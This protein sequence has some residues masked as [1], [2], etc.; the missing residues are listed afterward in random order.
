MRGAVHFR[1]SGRPL[2]LMGSMEHRSARQDVRH[3]WRRQGLLRHGLQPDDRLVRC[4]TGAAA[5]GFGRTVLDRAPRRCLI[6]RSGVRHVT[7]GT[8]AP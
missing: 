8:R 3:L 7:S 5:R 6:E 1:A 2:R 4:T